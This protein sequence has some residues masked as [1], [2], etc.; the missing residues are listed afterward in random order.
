MLD[1]GSTFADTAATHG[2]G[3]WHPMPSWV[4]IRE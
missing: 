1:A 2:A 4:R 3:R